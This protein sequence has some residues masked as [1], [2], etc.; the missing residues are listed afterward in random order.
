MQAEHI[1]V[2]NNLATNSDRRYATARD[3]RVAGWARQEK[4]P[5]SEFP[6]NGVVRR[7]AVRDGWAQ[8]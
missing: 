5:W 4:V 1:T 3:R 8:R 6:S 2:S 7:L